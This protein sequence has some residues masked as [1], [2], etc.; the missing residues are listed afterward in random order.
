MV[1]GFIAATR[2]HAW[3]MY[4]ACMDSNHCEQL[5]SLCFSLLNSFF[6]SLSLSTS[7]FRAWSY[8][9]MGVGHVCACMH[10]IRMNTMAQASST[11]NMR[12]DACQTCMVSCLL[13]T[14]CLVDQYSR[15]SCT[16]C[17]VRCP[18]PPVCGPSATVSCRVHPGF[19][20]DFEP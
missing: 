11:H 7:S 9:C 17:F 15:C 13:S 18:P 5:L 12:T 10:H 19:R 2:E 20:V 4:G 1:W 14:W 16:S 6:A 8:V 3:S